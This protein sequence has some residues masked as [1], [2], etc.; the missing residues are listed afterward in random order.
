ML[1]WIKRILL[2]VVSFAVVLLLI[3]LLSAVRAE[4][5]PENHTQQV[6]PVA[7]YEDIIDQLDLDS[8]RNLVGANKH[9]PE[10]FELQAL[11]ALSAFPELKDVEISFILNDYSAPMEA[12]M[13]I[14]TLFGPRKNRHYHVLLNVSDDEWISAIHLQNLPF[15]AQVGILAHELAHI[16]YYHRLNLFQMGHWGLRYLIS[17]KYRG[18]HEKTTDLAPVWRGQGNQ[19]Y[20]YAY[21]VRYSETTSPLYSQFSSFIDNFY[22]NDEQIKENMNKMSIY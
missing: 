17:A 15:D 6:E 11:L 5:L 2:G 13:E 22:L 9:L 7:S 4:Q 20:Q 14:P 18:D 3:V 10:G 12:N 21:Y 16:S 1:K 8:L 19:I